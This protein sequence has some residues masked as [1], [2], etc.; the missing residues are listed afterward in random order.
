MSALLVAAQTAS[1]P[2]RD[3]A[4]PRTQ[5]KLSRPSADEPIAKEFSLKR[6]VAL[7]DSA[8]L[9][10]TRQHNCGSC[11]T[12][13]PYHQ[14]MLLWAATWLD[15]LMDSDQ[16]A[17]TVRSL[18]ALQ[19]ADGGWCLPSLGQWKRRNGQPNDPGSPSDGCATGLIVFVLREAGVPATDPAIQR[20]IAWLKSH[21]RASGR[22]FTRSLN[23]DEDHYIT[24][25]GTCL[26]VMSLRR[27]ASAGEPT[28]THATQSAPD[29]ASS[30]P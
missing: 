17:A 28:L 24:D 22:W 29:R 18:W 25:V 9:Q 26:A 4:S 23:D 2:A 8:A 5:E 14:T 13:Y 15:G 6:W 1:P 21:Q 10:W 11:H 27:C 3:M 30:R 16:K 20:G 19:R 7:I 12:N